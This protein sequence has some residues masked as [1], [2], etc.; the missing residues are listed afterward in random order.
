MT[1][2]HIVGLG[3]LGGALRLAWATAGVPL[4]K[5]VAE[6]DTVVLTVPDDAI[7]G[8]AASL[9]GRL[10][11]GAV[12]LHCAGALDSAVLR[13]SGAAAVGSLHPLQT[14][15][16]PETGAAALAGAW[17]G[18]E[19]DP[20]AIERAESLASA[21]GLRT[22]RLTAEMKPL[23]HAAAVLACN[24]LVALLHIAD[25]LLVDVVGVRSGIE[26][27]LPLVRAT[28]DNVEANGLRASLTG[29]IARGDEGTVARHQAVLED[30]PLA[31]S[32]YEALA[33][34][35]RDLATR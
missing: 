35:A 24:D 6:A 31:K 4:T 25:R 14:V 18:V 21:A 27:L 3:R 2:V 7:A 13:P 12:A 22:V 23:W 10:R 32:A 26:V 34:A 17:A 1:T 11:R 29:P 5:V 30:H 28:L 33:A 8:V 19:G 20:T 16:D 15:L 9:S